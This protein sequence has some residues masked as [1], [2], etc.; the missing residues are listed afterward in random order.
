MIP[1]L[2]TPMYYQMSNEHHCV[3][4]Y[5]NVQNVLHNLQFF[6]LHHLHSNGQELQHLVPFLQ[7]HLPISL[8]PQ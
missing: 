8:I 1:M 7:Y 6:V 2:N 4:V 3:P 5:Y